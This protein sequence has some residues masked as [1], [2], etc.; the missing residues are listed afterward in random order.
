MK[1]TFTINQL[2]FELDA[3]EARLLF[4][5]VAQI[6]EIFEA[7]T[8]CG[9]CE[10]EE[11]RY[12]FRISGTYEFYE[13]TCRACAAQFR[14]GQRKGTLELFPKRKDDAGESLPN[15]GWSVWTPRD[16]HDSRPAKREEAPAPR[17]AAPQG[18]GTG[19]PTVLKFPNWDTAEKAP[20]WQRQ[21]DYIWEIEGQGAWF[22]P[23]GKRDF[24]V[25]TGPTR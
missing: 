20:E 25:W 23:P 10:S 4:Q 3:P 13:L 19:R 16:E 8:R 2:Q 5:Q 11:I 17:A 9:C 7:E 24:A 1:A 18:N 6:Q 22:I 15:H 12:S 14:F 21:R